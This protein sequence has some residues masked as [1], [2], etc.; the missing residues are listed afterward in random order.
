MTSREILEGY[1]KAQEI[2]N[3]LLSTGAHRKTFRSDE[4]M[5]NSSGKTRAV[6]DSGRVSGFSVNAGE[7]KN[8]QKRA[9]EAPETQEDMR[10]ARLKRFGG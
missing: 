9:A 2:L 5:F 6:A 7:E 4:A 10:K 3:T 1:G 8:N